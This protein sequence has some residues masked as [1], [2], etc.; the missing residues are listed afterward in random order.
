LTKD[1]LI[2]LAKQIAAAYNL[3]PALVCA[4][5]EEES[6]WRMDATRFEPAFKK[7]YVDPLGLSEPEA[8]YRATSWGGCQVMGEVAREFGFVFDIPTLCD[9]ATGIEWG[10]KILQHKIGQANGNVEAGLLRY[11]G[12]GN[13]DYADQVIAR[14]EKYLPLADGLSATQS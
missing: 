14:M 10:C 3:D 5:I 2:A 7:R 6:G 13:P 4:L 9:P 11:N 12:G 1:E 8:T